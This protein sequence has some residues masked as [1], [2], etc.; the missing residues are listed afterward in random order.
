MTARD[1]Q[2]LRWGVAVVGVSWLLLRGL[3]GI[4]QSERL[5][6]ERVAAKAAQRD[7]AVSDLH[8]LDSLERAAGQVESR[9]HAL[10]PRLLSGTTASAAAADVS[11]RTR[12]LI[13]AQGARVERIQGL[14]DSSAA[15]G[16]RRSGLRLEITT[17][18]PG[19]FDVL[20][21]IERYP[22]VLS[23]SFVRIVSNDAGLAS[24]APESLRVELGVSGFYLA[25]KGSP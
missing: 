4:M 20:R 10:A 22:A 15:G 25:A 24:E 19:L 21:A 16:L 12:A 1:R 14:G 13:E 2:V 11:A 9:I 8:S 7:R 6:R 3:P 5:L 18:T 23:V 17:D